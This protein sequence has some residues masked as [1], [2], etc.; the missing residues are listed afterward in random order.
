[1]SAARPV[2]D[3][4]E[5]E[6]LG[7]RGVSG[8]VWARDRRPGKSARERRKEGKKMYVPGSQTEPGTYRVF[9]RVRRVLT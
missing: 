8:N 2:G 6:L 9:T 1:V 7:E 3:L 4:F 5:A